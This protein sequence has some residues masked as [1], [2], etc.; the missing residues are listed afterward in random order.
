MKIGI[1]KEIKQNENR[2]AATPVGVKALVHDG[3]EVFVQRSAGVGSGISDAHF[4]KA[5]AEMLANP[6]AV[7]S[8]S[9]LVLKV[10]EPMKKE[11]GFFRE[12]QILFTYFHFA[13][14]PEMANAMIKSLATCVAYETVQT[15]DGKLPLLAPM[16]EVAGKMA[17]QI[18]AYYLAKPPG[19][20]VLIS[21]VAGTK[22]AKVT[23]L[24]AGN[25]GLAAANVASAMGAEVTLLEIS[26][27]KIKMLR[28]TMPQNVS[29]VKSNAANIMHYV[30]ETDV[31]VGAVLVPGKR[32]PVVVTKEM[33][34]SM[35]AGS[36]IV[37]IAIDQGG[38]IA[39]SRP[40][41]HK[42][43]IYIHNGIVH[44]CVTNM[45]AAFPQTSTYALTSAT[46]P[47]ARL[48]AKHGEKAFR[49]NN[50]LL[51]GLGICRGT[52]TNKQLSESLK[53]KYTPALEALKF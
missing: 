6:A 19:K 34:C 25:A 21:S 23:V 39:T 3:H 35:E 5:G 24:G 20:G 1:L 47:Y 52:V 22:P 31:L 30:R 26:D 2:V 49:K 15:P 29:I 17:V 4:R 50:A 41:T 28:K 45:P 44:Y 14:A 51:S 32:A 46:L 43:P 7:A 8:R 53:L 13:S 48:L 42:D 12:G 36:V 18:G 10:K 37:D 16:S 27:K 9:D 33:V 11:Y 38:C 40:T